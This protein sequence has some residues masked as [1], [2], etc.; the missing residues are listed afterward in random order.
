[1]EERKRTE[2]RLRRELNR[3]PNDEELA[4][5]MGMTI[6]YYDQ[7]FG[8]GL[9][10]APTGSMPSGEGADDGMPALEVVADPEADAP[11]EALSK[12]E[13]LGLV[14]DK[15]SDQEYRIIYLK[16]FNDLPMREI[17]Q[18]TGLSESRVCKIH[19]RLLDRLKDRFRVNSELEG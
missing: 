13:L 4:E 7:R 15:L 6:E 18:L 2:E 8:V 16:Y 19:A 12:N 14:T 3:E 11:H 5:A 10:G 9:P 1:L 17:G